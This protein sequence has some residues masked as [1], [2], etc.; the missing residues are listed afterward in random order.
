MIRLHCGSNNSENELRCIDDHN[1]VVYGS[2]IGVREH[3]SVG[4]PRAE[5]SSAREWT[6]TT[7]HITENLSHNQCS[8]YPSSPQ[9]Q[10]L[11]WK[12]RSLLQLCFQFFFGFSPPRAVTTIAKHIVQLVALTA[13]YNPVVTWSFV[14]PLSEQ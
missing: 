12:P 7:L 6:R 11:L 3:E 5:I 1:R 4:R 8:C 13:A 14:S 2:E 10:F 9:R